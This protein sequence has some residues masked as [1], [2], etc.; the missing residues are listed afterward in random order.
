[1]PG[2]KLCGVPVQCP[3]M[4]AT[5]KRKRAKHAKS[6]VRISES[7]RLVRKDSHARPGAP[8]KRAPDS[9]CQGRK[10]SEDGYCKQPAGHGTEH[11]G[12][13]RC[14]K[15]GGNTPNGKKAAAKLMAESL[16]HAYGLPKDIDPQDAL[17]EELHRTAGHVG[18]LQTLVAA[19]EED[20]LHGEVGTTGHSEGKT[21]LAKSEPNVL[22]RMYQTERKM[23]ERI[24]K[25]CIEAG[26]EERRV[27]IAEDQGKLFAQVVQGILKDLDIDA[28]DPDVQTTVR[29]NF[30]LIDNT[31]QSA[32][33][34]LQ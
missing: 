23:L 10:V 3:A 21:F 31:D 9:K 14:K 18:Y 32:V 4:P 7:E 22:V 6:K 5:G 29:R 30:T 28:T 2:C 20:D 25:S 24:A 26:I 8:P 11:V 34:H 13:G 19:L 33:A 27:R 12:Y 16:A 17:I 1:M 15:H